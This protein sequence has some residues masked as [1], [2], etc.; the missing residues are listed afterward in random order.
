M[1]RPKKFHTKNDVNH[2]TY[3]IRS[4]WTGVPNVNLFDFM[5]VLVN[6]GKVLCSSAN[7]L[8]QNSSASSKEKYVL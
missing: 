1:P 2:V 6:Y 5:F 4:S 8:Q 7:E 3:R